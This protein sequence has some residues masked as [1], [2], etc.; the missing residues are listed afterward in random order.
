MTNFW[1]SFIKSAEKKTKAPNFI[2]EEAKALGFGKQPPEKKEKKVKNPP[3]EA[4]AA[5]QLVFGSHQTNMEA[6]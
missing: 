6:K 2:L 5:D 1:K 3:P 4:T